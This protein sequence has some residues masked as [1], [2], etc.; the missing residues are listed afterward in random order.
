[1]ATDTVVA[2]TH[3]QWIPVTDDIHVSAIVVDDGAV[4]TYTEGTDY[5]Y[6]TRLNMIK[7]LSTG[8]IPDGA[9]VTING[10]KAAVTGQRISVAT[11]TATR[12]KIVVDGL[13]LA[14]AGNPD[15]L[16]TAWQVLLTPDGDLDIIGESHVNPSFTCTFETPSNRTEPITLDFPEVG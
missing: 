6:N 14:E 3:D 9:D 4:T 16:A 15:V 13:N 2:V 8:A 10:T 5:E 12:V 1:M 11:K 7:A